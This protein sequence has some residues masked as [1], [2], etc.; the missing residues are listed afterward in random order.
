MA[1][2]DKARI[3]ANPGAETPTMNDHA[4]DAA[5]VDCAVG[6]ERRWRNGKDALG[7]DRKHGICLCLEGRWF[8]DDHGFVA[9]LASARKWRQFH[10]LGLN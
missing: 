8:P 10:L 1:A 2:C 6:E 4:V 3:A 5:H 9:L 7:V